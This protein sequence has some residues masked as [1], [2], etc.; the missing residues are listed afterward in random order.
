MPNGGCRPNCCLY[1]IHMYGG[2]YKNDRRLGLGLGIG[3]VCSLPDDGVWSPI[4]MNAVK[5]TIWST[6][7]IRHRQPLYDGPRPHRVLTL[8]C[9]LVNIHEVQIGCQSDNPS[10]YSL[11]PLAPPTLSCVYTWIKWCARAQREMGV[12]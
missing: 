7:T 11:P 12:V 10:G 1:G 6:P 2:P 5:T 4:H 3:L 8:Q 9:W